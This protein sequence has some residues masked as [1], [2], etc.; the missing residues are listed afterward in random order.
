MYF[1]IASKWPSSILYSD[2]I[3]ILIVFKLKETLYSIC[4]A[5]DLGIDIG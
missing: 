3:F 2:K 5:P 4:S 1:Q